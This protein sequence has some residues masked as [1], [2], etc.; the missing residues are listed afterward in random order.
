MS[1]VHDRFAPINRE[2]SDAL[3]D[4]LEAWILTSMNVVLRVLPIALQLP[5]YTRSGINEGFD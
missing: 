1:V 3:Q 4:L 2:S 5:S